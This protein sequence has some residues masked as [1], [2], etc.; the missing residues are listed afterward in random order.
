MIIL[1]GLGSISGA[2]IGAVILTIL[3]ELLRFFGETVSQW[4][5]VIYSVLFNCSHA[6]K[7]DGILGKREINLLWF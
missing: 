7:P 1:G 6:F 3:P 5:M 2:V 4:R